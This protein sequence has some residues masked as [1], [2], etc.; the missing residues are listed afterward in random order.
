MRN[1]QAYAHDVLLCR[2]VF[3]FVEEAEIQ[4]VV[5]SGVVVAIISIGIG[6]NFVRL[7]YVPFQILQYAWESCVCKQLAPYLHLRS[8]KL[9]C[10]CVLRGRVLRFSAGLQPLSNGEV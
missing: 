4:L 7:H 2:L 1:S 9:F 10:V 8:V 5:V 3:V 6:M